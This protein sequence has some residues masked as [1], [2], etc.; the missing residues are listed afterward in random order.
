MKFVLILVLC[1]FSCSATPPKKTFETRTYISEY[2]IGCVY[3]RISDVEMRRTCAG[4]HD[5]PPNL[6]LIDL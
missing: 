4:D 6:I 2:E 5:Y 3:Y 1:M